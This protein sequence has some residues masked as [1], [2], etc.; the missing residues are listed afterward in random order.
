M[1]T[2]TEYAVKAER[3]RIKNLT[4]LGAH[5][6]AQPLADELIASGKEIDETVRARF[7]AAELKITNA[8]NK[9]EPFDRTEDAARVV[10]KSMGLID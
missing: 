7:V 8:N 3:L 4:A 6:Q 1:G 10:A 9:T 2:T 5:H